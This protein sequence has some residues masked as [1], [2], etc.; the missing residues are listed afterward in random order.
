MPV[1]GQIEYDVSNT[2]LTMD[3]EKLAIENGAIK[4]GGTYYIPL[5]NTIK[6]VFDNNSQF[7]AFKKQ[8][9]N[10]FSSVKVKEFFS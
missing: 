3:I 8:C 6:V 7:K 2:Q 4:I 10:N 9:E 5:S 1:T